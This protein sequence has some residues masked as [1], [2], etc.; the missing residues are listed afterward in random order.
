[1]ASIAR[2]ALTLSAAA[3]A[4]YAFAL[5]AV[6]GMRAPFLQERFAS[7]P[8]AVWVHIAGGGS[9]LLLGPLQLSRRLRARRVALHRALGTTYL[10]AVLAAGLAGFALALVSEGGVV[11]H[12]GFGAL[13]VAWLG[14]TSTAYARIRA[15]DRASHG[16]WMVR[17]YALT[18]AAVTLRIQLPV[19][20]AAG[21][22]FE[23]AY[24][25]IAWLCWV[26]NLFIAE[27]LLAR[28]TPLSRPSA[29]GTPVSAA[30]SSR[31]P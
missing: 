18:F 10:A 17:S 24:P 22:P 30:R 2:G 26:P 6:P 13:A 3:V 9:A 14:T 27:W 21:I 29:L 1:L 8:L 20:Q 31:T 4:A 28:R 7:L 16:R 23:V 11:A 12:A 19:S 25:A 15:G 5:L